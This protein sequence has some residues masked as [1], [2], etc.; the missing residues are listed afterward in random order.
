MLLTARNSTRASISYTLAHPLRIPA[1]R[2]LSLQGT[3]LS[4]ATVDL[5]SRRK[6]RSFR[7]RRAFSPVIVARRDQTR[8][9]FR[10]SGR[11]SLH[12]STI[13][14]LVDIAS[15]RVAK[16]LE[17]P[18][19]FYP[20]ANTARVF[21]RLPRNIGLFESRPSSALTSA[22]EAVYRALRGLRATEASSASLAGR[23]RRMGRDSRVGTEN[24]SGTSP[25]PISNS[26]HSPTRRHSADPFAH[27]T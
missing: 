14:R 12:P 16:C 20:D 13:R 1:R 11:H 10:A 23:Q 7:D 5:A 15:R 18:L 9:I 8:R 21:S 22:P 4:H 3:S 27:V 6:T 17:R 19:Q 25:L 26:V 2:R 24:R